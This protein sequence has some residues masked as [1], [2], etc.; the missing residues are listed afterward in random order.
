MFAALDPSDLIALMGLFA[1]CFIATMGG[2]W[3]LSGWMSR[4][5][6]EVK[7]L[8]YKKADELVVKLEYHEEHDDRRFGELKDDLWLLRVRQAAKDG[9]IN[10]NEDHLNS[11]KR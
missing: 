11:Q 2:I 5:F 4:Q 8:V 3:T 10:G 6:R 7:N 9:I 1:T